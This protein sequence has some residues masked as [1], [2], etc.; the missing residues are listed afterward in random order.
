[1]LEAAQAVFA[2]KGYA[3]A[4][5]DEIAGRAEF[6]KGTL[7]NYFEGGKEAI[8]FAIFD[9]IYQDL[10]NLIQGALEKQPEAEASHCVFHSMIREVFRFFLERE[11]LFFILMK[12]ECRC[13]FGEDDKKAAFVRRHEERLIEALVPAIEAAQEAG[14]F[15]PLPAYAVAHMLLG[16][17]NGIVMHVIMAHHRPDGC[18]SAIQTPD[19]AADFLT[20]MLFHGLLV[21]DTNA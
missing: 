17:I 8:L 7:Y 16:N 10:C 13:L 5:L 11:E 9:E 14:T 2:E 18:E 1:M 3:R 4:T 19:Q 15:K 21:A 20:T 6:G 12:E